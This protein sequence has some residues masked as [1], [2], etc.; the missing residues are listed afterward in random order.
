MSFEATYYGAN[1]WLIQLG[2]IR[3]LIDPWLR[4]DLTFGIGEWLIKGELK[5]KL[6]LP[7]KIN[8]VLLTQGL[9]D[10]THLPSLALIDKET[11]IIASPK[12]AKNVSALNFNN[13]IIIRP[14]EVTEIYGIVIQATQGAKVPN[15]ENGYLIGHPCGSLYIEPHGF[16]DESIKPREVD[17]LITPVVDLGLPMIGPFIKGK[18]ILPKL[19]KT[20]SPKNILASTTGGDIRFKGMLNKLI[21]QNGTPKEAHDLIRSNINLINPDPGVTY[22]LD[23]HPLY[24]DDT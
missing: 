15:I 10:H 14:K 8:L 5:R 21:R 7:K 17:T 12:A 16:L 6:T 2:E 13:I 3:I 4:G 9:A 19:I 1:G 22:K 23:R 24:L 11:P 18:S 20:F